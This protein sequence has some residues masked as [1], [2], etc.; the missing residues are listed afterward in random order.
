MTQVL[1][2]RAQAR[3][4]VGV[5]QGVRFQSILQGGLARSWLLRARGEGDES[6][7]FTPELTP[8]T[9]YLDKEQV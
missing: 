6:F 8:W 5:A 2:A 3:V 4:G 1:M 7:A 9:T